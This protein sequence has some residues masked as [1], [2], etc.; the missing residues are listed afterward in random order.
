M[1]IIG[2]SEGGF[3]ISATKDE[4]CKILGYPHLEYADEKNCT[5]AQNEFRKL[6][7]IRDWVGKDI[8][9][10]ELYFAGRFMAVAWNEKSRIKDTVKALREVA[11]DLLK[12]GEIYHLSD[13]KETP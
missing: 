6:R 4:V 12:V 13:K 1:K 10:D 9:I 7:D 2:H 11:D 5:A 8:P 3:L